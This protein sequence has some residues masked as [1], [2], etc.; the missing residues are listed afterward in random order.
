MGVVRV[1]QV[2]VVRVCQVGVCGGMRLTLGMINAH[3]LM[4]L[5]KVPDD[6]VS[7]GRGEGCVRWAWGMRLS[8]HD[9]CP[10]PDGPH[11]GTG[12]GCQLGVVRGVSG[13]RN[14]GVSGG[15]GEG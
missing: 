5:M 7:D 8:G 14:E 15:R 10:C 1:C 9:Q 13:G 12:W 11:K 2:G 3:V 6:G 4:D